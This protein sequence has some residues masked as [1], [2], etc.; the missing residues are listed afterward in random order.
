MPLPVAEQDDLQRAVFQRIAVRVGIRVVLPCY[1]AVEK[2]GQR[3]Q[4][5]R[6]ADG[7]HSLSELSLRR[8]CG[9]AHPQIITQGKMIAKPATAAT[10][11]CHPAA[12]LTIHCVG[13]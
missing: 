1:P 10:L 5:Q 13:D 3:S 9:R 7:K 11:E 12:V 6:K 2:D 8:L 4:C